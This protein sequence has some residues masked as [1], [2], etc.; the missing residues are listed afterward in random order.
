MS[1]CNV[2]P[3][4]IPIAPPPSIAIT[5]AINPPN[6]TLGSDVELS[7]TAVSKAPYPVT[8]DTWWT[9][10]NPKIQ[11][12]LGS[13]VGVDKDTHEELMLHSAHF[14]MAPAF[15]DDHTLGGS[16]DEYFV[17]LEPGQ[18]RVFNTSFIAAYGSEDYPPDVMPSLRY[19]IDLR[20]SEEINWWKKGRKEDVLDLPGQNRE[21]GRADGKPI[22]LK[23]D[24]PVE[25]AVL[26]PALE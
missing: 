3:T 18:P 14:H 7:V 21:A 1:P 20:E 26:P 2:N 23:L 5:L 24:V 10:L 8:V 4:G 22:A 6:F 17:T 13:L 12:G 16:H 11:Q 9:I 25:F 19:L 15:L